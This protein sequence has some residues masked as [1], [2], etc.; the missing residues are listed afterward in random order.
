MDGWMD[1]QIAPSC[2]CKWL[3]DL[4]SGGQSPAAGGGEPRRSGS[5]GGGGLPRRHVAGKDPERPGWHCP[6]AAPH[7]Q[8]STEPAFASRVLTGNIHHDGSLD[9][10]QSFL[11][12]FNLLF[13]P[14]SNISWKP[15]NR[16]VLSLYLKEIWGAIQ[17]AKLC[18]FAAITRD[19]SWK[20]VQNRL[21]HAVLCVWMFL[22][23]N[24][25]I[26]VFCGLMCEWSPCF[27]CLCICC[28]LIKSVFVDIYEWNDWNWS[29]KK[30]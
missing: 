15:Q 20:R 2:H 11:S 24:I 8:R 29:L 1:R 4:S 16:N 7:P 9:N 23:K 5:S 3:C 21:I 10:F 6:V 14:P 30:P 13:F 25:T 22:L 17:S 26:E 28:I 19:A 12:H 18:R 27:L